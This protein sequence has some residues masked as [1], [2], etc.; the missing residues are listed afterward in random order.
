MPYLLFLLLSFLWGTS[1]ILIKKASL[2]FDP[3]SIAALRAVGA[4][5]VL[6]FVIK[7]LQHAWK[8]KKKYI[9]PIT[10]TAFVGIVYPFTIQSVLIGWYG[11][12]FIAT[13][14][15]LLPLFTILIS[16]PMLGES[17]SK[18][19][20]LGV[21]GGLVCLA[22]LFNE[23]LNR[24][25][26]LAG[27]FLAATVPLCFAINNVY[28]KKRLNHLP[29][30]Q[31]AFSFQ[32]ASALALL[33]TS[34][35][36][37]GVRVDENLYFALGAMIALSILGTGLAMYI[38]YKLIQD[39]GPLFAGMISYTVPVVALVWGWLDAEA[40]SASQLLALSGIL[41]SVAFVQ[42]STLHA[43]KKKTAE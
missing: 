41:G 20:L 24:N 26:S 16:I 11:S 42:R 27:L 8:V 5:L 34:I 31:L 18:A 3:F 33:P 17:P 28:I 14:L 29:P 40:I 43:Q 21:I 37:E 23:G 2:M 9:L 19:Q 22:V 7:G 25:Y 39:H 4:A 35:A 38:F 10:A 1:F 6:S 36:L 30:V 32:L 15:S 13:I 12:A